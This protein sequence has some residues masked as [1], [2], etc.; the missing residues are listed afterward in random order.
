MGR[1]GGRTLAG[2][3]R[4]KDGSS[5]RGAPSIDPG[6]SERPGAQ[7]R[8]LFSACLEMLHE[9]QGGILRVPQSGELLDG[10]KSHSLVERACLTVR[11]A[12]VRRAKR[13]DV[14]HSDALVAQPRFSGFK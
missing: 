6:A 12:R 14:K 9:E 3:R 11:R 8:E 2:P 7:M 4:V 13:L 5:R 1:H 10:H